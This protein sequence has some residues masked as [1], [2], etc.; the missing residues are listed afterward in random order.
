MLGRLLAA[1]H[2]V[3]ALTVVERLDVVEQIGLRPGLCGIAVP[4]TRSFFRP[5]KKDGSGG[6]ERIVMFLV[7]EKDLDGPTNRRMSAK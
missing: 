3:A 7:V 6:H 5:L 1:E 4:C 2:R